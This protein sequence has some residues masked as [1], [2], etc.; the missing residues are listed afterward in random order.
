MRC[1][2]KGD[3]FRDFPI[4]GKWK[5]ILSRYDMTLASG[6]RTAV[7]TSAP[8]NGAVP[9]PRNMSRTDLAK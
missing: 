5:L 7:M 3:I 2:T 9:D 1:D 4:N 8:M 6:R